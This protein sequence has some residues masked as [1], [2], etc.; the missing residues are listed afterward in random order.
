MNKNIILAACLTAALASCN[1]V[2]VPEYQPMSLD[3]A[4]T[5]VAETKGLVTG[6][7]LPSGSSVGLFVTD[8]T[9]VTYDGVEVSNVKYTAA[10]EGASQSWS[11]VS[12]IMLSGTKGTLKG[13][14]PYSESVTDITAI[15]VEATSEIQNDWM[16]ATP[17]GNLNYKYY[18]ATVKMNHALAAV[19]LSV[20][21]KTATDDAEITSITFKSNAAASEAVLN[22][23]NGALS[24]ISGTGAKYTASETFTAS[25]VKKSFDFITV[26]AGVSAPIAVELTVN[27]SKMTAE[28]DPVLLEAGNLYEYTLVISV[29]EGLSMNTLNVTEWSTVENEELVDLLSKPSEISIPDP[30]VEWARIQHMDGTLYTAE[31][32]LAAEA[33]GTVTDADANGVAVLYSTYEVCPHVVAPYSTSL[34]F[35]SNISVE[36]PSVNTVSDHGHPNYLAYHDIKGQANTEAILAAVANGTIEDAPAAEYCTN[37]TLPNGQKGYM[38]ALGEVK[39]WIDNKTMFNECMAAI[40]GI[41]VENYVDYSSSTQKSSTQHYYYTG[42]AYGMSVSY[43][44]KNNKS[45]VIPVFAFSL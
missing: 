35:S 43:K 15:P 1:Q 12:D 8:Q 28:S 44:E 4:V 9:G 14:Y 27:G 5:T 16:W 34:M 41:K 42:N 30:Y 21:R 37:A 29:N 13:Y 19:R 20:I 6:T 11:A 23:T 24:S 3:I 45:R 26:P 33:A 25:D 7:T 2:E 38:P 32:W 18:N 22:A 40:G 17:I 36:I 10:G 39:A 31:E